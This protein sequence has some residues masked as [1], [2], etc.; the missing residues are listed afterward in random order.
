MPWLIDGQT[1][2]QGTLLEDALAL[3]KVTPLEGAPWLAQLR[4]QFSEDSLQRLAQTLMHGW[5]F[6]GGPPKEKWALHA[7]AHFPSDA[8]IEFL[9][10]GAAELASSTLSA[11]AREFVDVLAAMNTRAS[12][13][14]VYA[15]SRKVRAR[16]FRVKAVVAFAAAAERMG[17]T[18]LELSER[19]VPDY[20]LTPEGVL[21]LTPKVRL[22]LDGL[23]PKWLDDSGNALKALPEIADEAVA[24]EMAELKRKAASLAREIAERLERRMTQVAR[25]S[26]E[27]F[28]EVYAQ[29]GI[30]RQAARHVLFGVYSSE[31]LRTPFL[32]DDSPAF[33]AESSVGVVH[34]LELSEVD[35]AHW[36]ARLPK[37]PFEQLARV[38]TAFA[39]QA[40]FERAVYAFRGRTVASGSI[41]GLE[42]RGWQRGDVE[43]GGCYSETAR[44]FGDFEV[45]AQFEPGIFVGDPT[46]HPQ[47]LITRV[48]C[49]TG[50]PPSPVVM[51]E[52]LYDLTRAFAP[53]RN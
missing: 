13:K 21:P 44:K 9:G 45:V 46:L 30:A 25:M 43:G 7:V 11:R 20:G 52:L 24:S 26:V 23:K 41:L 51:S 49:A 16:A 40:A 27:H 14:Q 31:A 34:P 19:L 4:S 42:Q 36:G 22:V 33:S 17:M 29:H 28:T 38:T 12:L 1:A 48:V 6:A 47:Q 32:I 50:S 53:P 2:L 39:N 3:L 8:V 15:L 10:A 18:H 5:L 37:Q 35:R